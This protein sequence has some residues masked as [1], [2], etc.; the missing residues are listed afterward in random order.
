MDL[1][2]PAEEAITLRTIGAFGM[3]ALAAAVGLPSFALADDAR[4]L[5]HI[6]V[7][8]EE[9]AEF[10]SIIGNPK[11]PT[12]NALASRY[13][14]ATQSFGVTH[15]SEGNYVAMLGGDAYGI[16]DD[17]AFTSHTI[18]RPSLVDQL[19]GAGLTWKGY[20]Q[21]LPAAGY[22]GTCYPSAAVCL[23]AS[24]HN[25]FLNF[26]HVQQSDAEKARLVPDTDLATDLASPGMPDL[27]FIIPDQ[28]HDLHGLGDQCSDERL[29]ADS[30][31]YLA[32]TVQAI[33][34]SD[35][36]TQARSAIVVTFD[37]G[38]ED[39][40]LGCCGA[41]PGGG[42]IA[43]VVILSQ[44][45]GPQQDPAPYNHYSLVATI[46][47]AFGLGCQFQGQPV[48]LTCDTAHGVQ[49]MAPLFQLQ[50]G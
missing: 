34:G 17:N 11:A 50:P 36:W 39:S 18:A 47:A 21:S 40:T 20:F 30:D 6:F 48:G 12:L 4:Q 13:G 1:S 16:E 32:T 3:L 2:S 42:R 9:N 29:L 8:V 41:N 37:E 49:P 10:G 25:G 35:P 15:P 44:Q 19:E 26:A 33:M 14:L 23:Y 7:I 24:K 5:D 45:T 43:T 38:S 28:C 31:Q 27:S 22:A 46:Q